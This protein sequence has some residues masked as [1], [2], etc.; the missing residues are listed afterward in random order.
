MKK[1]LSDCDGYQVFVEVKKL[2][3]IDKN[4][5]TFYT[6]W[7]DAKNPE[8]FHK[9]FQLHLTDDELASLKDGLC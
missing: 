3:S 6:R 1:M 5:V 7:L 9:K 4:S 2:S 8:E